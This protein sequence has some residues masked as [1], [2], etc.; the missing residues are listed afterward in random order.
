MDSIIELIESGS[1]DKA[2]KLFLEIFDAEDVDDKGYIIGATLMEHY[3][4]WNTMFD[5]VRNGLKQYPSNYELYLLLGNYYL[6]FNPNQAYISYENALYHCLNSS[7]PVKE[8]IAEIIQLLD[9]CKENNHITVNNV[10]FVILSYNTLDYTKACIESIRH[11]CYSECYELIII[12]NASTDGSVEWLREQSD[13]IL[14]ENTK[15]LGFPAGCNQGIRAACSENDIFLLNSDTIMLPQSLF[16]LRIGL[17]HKD[18]VGAAGAG[19]E[20]AGNNQI[21]DKS[22]NSDEELIAFCSNLNS[23]NINP[24]ESKVYLIMFAMLIKRSAINKTGFLDERFSP[25]NFED[26]DYGLRLINNGYSCILCHNSFIFH[27]GS[28]SFGKDMNN[29]CKTILV[30]HEKFKDKWGFYDDFY[31]KARNDII[32]MLDADPDAMISIL[33]VD[34]GL[35]ATMD[36]I[37]Y[38]YP[39]AT[40]RGIEISKKIA[41]IG[42][43]RLDIQCGNI[44]TIKLNNSK[45]DYIILSDVFDHLIDPGK[46]LAKLKKNLVEQGYVIAGFNNL[47]NA[48]II[49][50]LLKGNFTYPDSGFLERKNLR[51]FTLNEI[52]TLFTEAG[53]SILQIATV[54]LPSESTEVHKDIFDTLLGIEG[55]AS[56]ESFDAYRYV[57]KASPII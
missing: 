57:I 41:S 39:H 1:W 44:E 35:G 16:W 37:K 51:Y 50:N 49:S 47:M 24:Y 27:F 36:K 54:S 12:D 6:I 11:T 32:C 23:P 46:V 56:R 52:K 5:F 3:R 10:S 15:N 19:T 26:N 8:D 30:N 20:Q 53:Y 25:G 2:L 31:T 43:Q 55:V 45:Y 28:T 7:N 42:S 33:E 22:F 13:I 38:L 18:N 21:I 14:I 40:V 48:S 4:E 29:Y 9:S 17:Y 34:C